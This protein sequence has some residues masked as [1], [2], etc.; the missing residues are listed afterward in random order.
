MKFD[1]NPNFTT[2]YIMSLEGSILCYRKDCRPG[3]R[4][5]LKDCGRTGAGNHYIGGP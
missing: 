4:A 1:S 3:W 5:Q 2:K